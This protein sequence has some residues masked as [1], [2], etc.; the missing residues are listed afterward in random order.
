L[1]TLISARHWPKVR[2]SSPISKLVQN[3]IDKRI[4]FTADDFISSIN[5]TLTFRQ[6]GREA[7]LLMLCHGAM[8]SI[9]RAV[10]HLEAENG[11]EKGKSSVCARHH[12]QL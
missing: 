12:Y 11:P 3:G 9:N 10:E 5:G 7:V 4:P 1:T 8:D 6:K 2:R